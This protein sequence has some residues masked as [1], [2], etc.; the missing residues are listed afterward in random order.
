MAQVLTVS[1]W[2]DDTQFARM[3]FAHNRRFHDFIRLGVKPVSYRTWDIDKNCWW[4]HA[5]K[6]PMLVAAA[7]RFFVHVD[8]RVLPDWVQLRIAARNGSDT[9]GGVSGL[10]RSS[11]KN[12]HVLLHL[13][14]SAP[15]SVVK[16]AYKALCLEH[17]PDRGGSVETLQKINAAYAQLQKK[18]RKQN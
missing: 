8:Y 6:L 17:H 3:R 10:V 13:Q 18:Y 12:P 14:P 1:D 7:R 5:D 2:N 15:W 16:A 9:S 4:V 11:D